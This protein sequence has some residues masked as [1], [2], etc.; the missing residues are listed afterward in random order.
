[1]FTLDQGYDHE[2]SLSQGCDHEN[3]SISNKKCKFILLFF[4]FI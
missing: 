4:S 1:M 2:D 3:S